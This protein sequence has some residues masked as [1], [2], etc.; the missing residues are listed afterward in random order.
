[1]QSLSPSMPSSVFPGARAGCIRTAFVPQLGA[2]GPVSP[3]RAEHSC[4]EAGQWNSVGFH[5]AAEGREAGL[6]CTQAGVG[7]CE[8]RGAQSCHPPATGHRPAGVPAFSREGHLQ[9]SATSNTREELTLPSQQGPGWLAT[10]ELPR[11]N[12]VSISPRPWH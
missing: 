6:G 3:L 5:E 7:R 11:P 1:M 2:I 8:G 9:I 10:W 12:A 4:G